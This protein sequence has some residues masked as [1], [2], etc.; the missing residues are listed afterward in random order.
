MNPNKKLFDYKN[1]QVEDWYQLAEADDYTIFILNITNNGKNL[2]A[3]F[4]SVKNDGRWYWSF[5]EEFSTT[6]SISQIEQIIK[7]WYKMEVRSE[8]N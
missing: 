7:D 6:E 1:L 4:F 5:D 8:N 2:G 3:I